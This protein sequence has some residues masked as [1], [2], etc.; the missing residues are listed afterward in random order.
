V[1]GENQTRTIKP[2]VTLKERE[3]TKQVCTLNFNLRE[4]LLETTDQE[5]RLL[6]DHFKDLFSLP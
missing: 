4:F 3:Q 5:Q 1:G 6:S 2:D